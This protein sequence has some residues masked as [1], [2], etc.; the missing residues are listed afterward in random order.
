MNKKTITLVA[1]PSILLILI[2]LFIYSLFE[3]NTHG[4]DVNTFEVSQ[5]NQKIN[6]I[7]PSPAKTNFIIILADDLGYGDIGINGTKAIKT[8]EIDKLATQGVNF[9]QGYASAPICSPSRAGLLTGRYPVRTGIIQPMGAANDTLMRKVSRE[10]MTF[11]SNLGA[12][13]NIGGANLTK[14]LPLDEYTIAEML[15]DNGYKTA[16][17]GKWHLGDFSVASQYHPKHYGFDKFIGFNMSND[18]W[19]VAFFRDENKEITDIG[20]DQDHYTKLFTDEAIKFIE[21]ADDKPFF[22]YLSQKDPHQPFFP[23]AKFKGA[24]DAGPYGDAVAEFDWSVGEIIKSLRENN[25]DENTLV[26]VTSDNGPWYQGSAGGLRG[27]KGQSFEGGFKVPTVLWGTKHIPANTIIDTPVMHIDF[28]ST[29]A[30]IAGISLVEDRIIDGESLLPLL[31]GE[32]NNLDNRSLYFFHD[33]DLEAVRKGKWKYINRNSH[34][35]WPVPLDKP[36]TTVGSALAMMNYTPPGQMESIPTLG[37]WPALYQLDIDS[38][39]SYN[40]AK[41]HIDKTQA[42]ATELNQFQQKF[43]INPR[44]WISK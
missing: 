18:D 4:L 2:V 39:E 36:D 5:T 22:I 23:S 17:F 13:D 41:K 10:V 30:E 28:M 3:R 24:S 11:A 43:I 37:E 7:L 8:P 31:A 19:P 26:I 25:L 21:N 44:G 9:T 34:Y 16:A 12:V 20:L 33:F 6:S 27:R 14:F 35:V 15:Q 40:V 32:E 42:L 29:I 1:A 38:N